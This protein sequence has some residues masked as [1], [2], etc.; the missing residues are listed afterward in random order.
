MTVVITLWYLLFRAHHLYFEIGC[1]KYW[2]IIQLNQRYPSIWK[3][4]F[5]IYPF[6]RGNNIGIQETKKEMN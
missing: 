5:V 4:H 3:Y 2:P 6:I 1:F